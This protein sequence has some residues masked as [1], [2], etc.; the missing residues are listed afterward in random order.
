M[1]ACLAT[2]DDE[3]AREINKRRSLLIINH[4]IE[5]SLLN[6]A[7]MG[8]Q[9]SFGKNEPCFFQPSQSHSKSSDF[10]VAGTNHQTTTS[11]HWLKS[12]LQKRKRRGRE[13]KRVTLA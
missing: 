9:T 5:D 3:S 1:K 12:Q 8:L 11:N 10:Q 6:W 4:I 2:S 13:K 7:V